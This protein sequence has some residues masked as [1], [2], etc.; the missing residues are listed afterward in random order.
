MR[1]P[2]DPPAPH[3]AADFLGRLAAAA[4]TD[5]AEAG[6]VLAAAAAR[7]RGVDRSGLA[8]RLA[9]AFADSRAHWA[10]RR[11]YAC[12]RI[13]DRLAPL[14]AAGA[15]RAALLRAAAEAADGELF[16]GEAPA[17]AAAL[18]AR[19]LRRA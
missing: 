15:S 16:P 18:V 12:A 14:L 2:L 7:A 1:H 8:A 10:L 4:L 6:A 9:H 17:Y 11:R 19:R 5:P 13:G 3:A